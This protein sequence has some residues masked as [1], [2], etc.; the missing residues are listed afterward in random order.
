[1]D[2]YHRQTRRSEQ[3]SGRDCQFCAVQDPN[4]E[5][6]NPVDRWVHGH[7]LD[8]AVSHISENGHVLHLISEIA[9]KRTSA[10]Q[11]EP[12]AKSA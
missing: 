8:S 3:P 6:R 4:F 1:M 5:K 11:V 7:P 2:S 10:P 9:R 12:L